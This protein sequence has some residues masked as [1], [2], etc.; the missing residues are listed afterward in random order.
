MLT[1]CVL[2]KVVPYLLLECIA[3]NKLQRQFATL[4]D[5]QVRDSLTGLNY[6]DTPLEAASVPS[7]SMFC[8]RHFRELTLDLHNV[9][10]S[11]PF[12]HSTTRFIVIRLWF[13]GVT[14]EIVWFNLF[15]I[16]VTDQICSIGFKM[17]YVTSFFYD[18]D[19]NIFSSISFQVDRLRHFLFL[20]VAPDD[21]PSL[22]R[23]CVYKHI[24]DIQTESITIGGSH[25]ELLR[26]GIAILP[27]NCAA[28]T[29]SSE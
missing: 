25:E 29:F 20:N 2:C 27:V 3:P 13:T 28:I 10:P 1:T 16:Q 14:I 5:C 12:N 22:C 8:R 11:N 9:I 15:T 19:M 4:F 7:L 26:A 6:P 21:T 18:L 24:H 17:K 23:R